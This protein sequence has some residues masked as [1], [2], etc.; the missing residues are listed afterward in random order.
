MI[1]KIEWVASALMCLVFLI[2]G[3]VLNSSI[4]ENKY[5]YVTN[6]VQVYKVDRLTITS[7]YHKAPPY[8]WGDPMPMI[9]GGYHWTVP[10]VTGWYREPYIYSNIWPLYI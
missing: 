2:L 5:I 4:R 7:E 3:M 8:Y 10:V 9:T 1:N 6:E